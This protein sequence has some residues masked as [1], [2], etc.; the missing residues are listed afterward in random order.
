MDQ[1][2]TKFVLPFAFPAVREVYIRT[3]A[4]QA[5]E[6]FKCQSHLNWA[7]VRGGDVF[8]CLSNTNIHKSKRVRS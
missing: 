2:Q 1:S 8:L 6:S 5:L 7:V 4:C 3:Q